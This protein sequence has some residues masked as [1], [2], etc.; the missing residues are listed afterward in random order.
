M[1]QQE[2]EGERD[3]ENGRNKTGSRPRF[4]GEKPYLPLLIQG[5]DG[6]EV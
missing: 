1:G 6:G 4:T 5:K 3:G 2:G